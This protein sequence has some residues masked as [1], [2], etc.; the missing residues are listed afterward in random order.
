[1]KFIPVINSACACIRTS[2][3]DDNFP[4]EGGGCVYLMILFESF[5]VFGLSR[6]NIIPGTL[7]GFARY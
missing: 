1:M 7:F 2:A 4:W 6:E 5:F 3:E